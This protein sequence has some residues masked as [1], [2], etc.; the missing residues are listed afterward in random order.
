MSLDPASEQIQSTDIQ[1]IKDGEITKIIT[2]RECIGVFIDEQG[3]RSEP[4]KFTKCTVQLRGTRAAVAQYQQ[5]QQQQAEA[6][7]NSK[8][9]AVAAPES[10]S[11]RKP[12]KKRKKA[13]GSDSRQ[14][15]KKFRKGHDLA[16]NYS[17][18]ILSE[19]ST[20]DRDIPSKNHPDIPSIPS[21]SP[22]HNACTLG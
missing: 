9:A 21:F 3:V 10:K 14:P 19:L 16:E 6:G 22:F 2:T 17:C 7:G 4:K 20:L 18:S 8:P 5:Q 11:K 1:E 13:A 15:V 12:Y